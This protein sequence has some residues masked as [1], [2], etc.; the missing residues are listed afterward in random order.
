MAYESSASASQDITEN[1]ITSG[2][3]TFGTATAVYS[4]PVMRTALPLTKIAL[5]SERYIS[6][7]YTQQAYRFFNNVNSTDVGSALAT[8]D[9]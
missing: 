5:A 4:G 1:R 9:S 7:T 3:A 2:G 8:Q 6:P